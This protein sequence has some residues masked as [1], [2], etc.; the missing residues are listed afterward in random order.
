MLRT[1]RELVVRMVLR[2]HSG[3]IDGFYDRFLLK[4]ISYDLILVIVGLHNQLMEINMLGL[5][6]IIPDIVIGYHNLPGSV[7][8]THS[9]HPSFGSLVLL[10]SLTTIATLA[11]FTRK[12]SIPSLDPTQQIFFRQTTRLTC[13]DLAINQRVIAQLTY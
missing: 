5:V 11:S 10:S 1:T 13:M 12:T 7:I 4:S 3:F 2:F 6:E 9:S 8:E